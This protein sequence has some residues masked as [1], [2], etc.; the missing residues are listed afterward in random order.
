MA[1]SSIMENN[2]KKRASAQRI[3]LVEAPE[4]VVWD[5]KSW[6]KYY[7]SSQIIFSIRKYIC[8]YPKSFIDLSLSFQEKDRN[9]KQLSCLMRSL[10]DFGSMI[11]CEWSLEAT[12][13]WKQGIPLSKYAEG[14]EQALTEGEMGEVVILLSGPEIHPSLA[15]P[16]SL[17]EISNIGC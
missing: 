3:L 2:N 7:L 9:D 8:V 14:K 6:S 4:N 17:G 5:P 12:M 11:P 13:V 10:K 1:P 15:V 16:S